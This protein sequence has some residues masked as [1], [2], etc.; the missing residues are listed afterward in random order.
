MYGFSRKSRPNKNVFLC[1]KFYFWRK[2]KEEKKIVQIIWI[3]I[4]KKLSE[5]QKQKYEPKIAH[6][7]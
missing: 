4:P 7:K 2:L 3:I 6:L 5:K 1:D